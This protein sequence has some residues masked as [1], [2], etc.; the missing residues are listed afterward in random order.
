MLMIDL[1]RLT[2]DPNLR[3]IDA[4]SVSNDHARLIIADWNGKREETI[5]KRN[6]YVS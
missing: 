5:L 6:M 4:I 1:I 2:F 3:F